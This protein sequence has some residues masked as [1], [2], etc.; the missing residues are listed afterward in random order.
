MSKYEA[1]TRHLSR[2]GEARVAMS[3]ADMERV[4]G[5]S[6]PHSARLHR[7]WWANSAHG[8]VQAKGWLDAGY[9]SREVDLEAEKLAFVRLDRSESA[10][11]RQSSGGKG[12]AETGAPFDG[13]ASGKNGEKPRRRHPLIGCMAGT[14][15][16]APGVDL[17]EPMFT[18]EEVD[19]WIERKAALI[20]GEKP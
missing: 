14:F 16:I 15:A 10:E 11:R 9:E 8:H 2:R 3:F 12:L 6:L 17:T 5:F 4:L 13:Q 7:P 19:A 20:R 18:D 1:L